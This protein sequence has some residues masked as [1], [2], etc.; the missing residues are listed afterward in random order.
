MTT[1]TSPMIDR[2]NSTTATRILNVVKLQFANPWTT[3]ILPWIILGAIFALNLAIWWII[4]ASAATDAARADVR[5]GLQYSGAIFYIFVYMLIVAV[6]TINLT[7]PL[8]LG[9]SVTRR[10]F[11]LG[12]SVVFVMLSAIYTIGLSTLGAI[13][14]A[15]DGWG[16]GGRMFSSQFYIGDAPWIDTAW[17]YFTTTLFFFFVGAAT[18]SVYVRWK[19]NGMIVFFAGL[20]VLVV[21]AAALVTATGSWAAVG[22][23]ITD[24]GAVGIASVSL[25]PTVV[26]GL[27]GYA[28]LR[29]ATPKN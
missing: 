11:Y 18:A 23:A 13:E 26:C 22:G 3:L 4:L 24:L 14:S 28:I 10:D 16:F 27:A 20:G 2:P 21:G 1:V 9:Y 8:A 29:R 7:F 19:S 17:I 6:Q 25:I 15:T 5:D 12:S